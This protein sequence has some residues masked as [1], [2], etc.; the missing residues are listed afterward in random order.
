MPFMI[1]TMRDLTKKMDKM[2][3]TNEAREQKDKEEKIIKWRK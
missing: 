3:T 2:E 1:Q